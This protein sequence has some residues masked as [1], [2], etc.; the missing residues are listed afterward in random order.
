VLQL[1][2]GAKDRHVVLVVEQE[3]VAVLAERDRVA[4]LFE[5][6][7]RAQRDPDVQLLRELRADAARGLP[8]RSRRESVAFEQYDVSCAEPPQVKGGGGA[9]GA[10][11]DYDNVRRLSGCC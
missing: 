1:E 2:R 4:E 6:A 11:T 3:E 8:G 10:A 7:E 9:E 5:L